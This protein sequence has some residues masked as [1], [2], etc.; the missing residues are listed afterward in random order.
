MA[1]YREQVHGSQFEVDVGCRGG[2]VGL[3]SE[4]KVY[5]VCEGGLDAGEEDRP[6]ETAVVG[7]GEGIEVDEG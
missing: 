7:G 3:K 5:G 2:G 6:A 1:R 4:G